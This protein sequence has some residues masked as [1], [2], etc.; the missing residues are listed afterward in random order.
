MSLPWIYPIPYCLCPTKGSEREI[1]VTLRR[2]IRFKNKR[3]RA[4]R[5]RSSLTTLRPSVSV[6]SDFFTRNAVKNNVLDFL[7]EVADKT[8]LSL[9]VNVNTVLIGDA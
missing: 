3:A 8:T 1:K 7:A 6:P 4:L 5:T 2:P 9:P